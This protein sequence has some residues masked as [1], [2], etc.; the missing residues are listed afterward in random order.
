VSI[1]A[2]VSSTTGSTRQWTASERSRSRPSPVTRRV[3]LIAAN[4]VIEIAIGRMQSMT[5]KG[6]V[7]GRD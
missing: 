1:G 6:P 2:E 5:H 4:A 3:Q 7:V